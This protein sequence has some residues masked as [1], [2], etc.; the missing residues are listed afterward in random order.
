[1]NKSGRLAMVKSVLGAIP[2]HQMLIIVPPKKMLKQIEK[3]QRG[4][5]WA[6][7]A[8]AQG[9]HCHVN[10]QHVCRPIEQGGLGV[11][12]LERTGLSL[13]IRWMWLGRTDDTRAWSGL[14][15]HFSPEE[16]QLFF[17]STSMMLG[18]GHRALFWEDRWISGRAISEIAP[19]L[20]NCVPKR[21][22][23]IRTVT[24]ALLGNS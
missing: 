6:G 13:R 23:R 20:Y 12:D 16:R 2:L 4:F 8:D 14:D 3:I 18:N 7:R 22:R 21:R 1:M 17:A 10:W 19:L 15:L 5:L 24:Q 9:G 11:R